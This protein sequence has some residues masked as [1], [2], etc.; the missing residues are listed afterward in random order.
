M[1][2]IVPYKA[3][4]ARQMKLQTAQAWAEQGLSDDD[5]RGLEGPHAGTVMEDGVP[6]LCGGA[7]PIWASRAVVWSLVSEKV[8]VRNFRG[9]HTVVKRFLAGLP[10][11]RLEVSVVKGFEPGCRWVEALGF[12][13]ESPLQEAF[14][15]DGSDAVGYVRI[16]K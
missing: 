5:L 14:L 2:Y 16:R 13:M 8:T 10:F 3:E 1:I 11:K 4:H 15:V 9:L 7:W 12:W 6:L